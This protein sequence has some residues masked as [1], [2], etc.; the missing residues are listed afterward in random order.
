MKRRWLIPAVVAFLAFS[1]K[2]NEKIQVDSVA[3]DYT[4]INSPTLSEP[5][6]VSGYHFQINPERTRARLVVDYTYPDEMIYLPNDDA[7]GPMPTV[8]QLPGLTYDAINHEVV[9]VASGQRTV[10]A[11]VA[12]KN[13]LLG[14]RIQVKN[15]GACTVSAVTANHAV[16]DGWTVHRISALDV[17]LNVD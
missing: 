7:K 4:P 5:V 16:D 11:T 14:H 12:E 17:Y 9:Y 2:A 15:T 1:A 6:S 13:G 3:P 10:C 8:V